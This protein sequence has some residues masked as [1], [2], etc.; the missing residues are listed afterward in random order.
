MTCLL[1]KV[2]NE[3][4][5][6]FICFINNARKRD[7]LLFYKTQTEIKLENISQNFKKYLTI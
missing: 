1:L 3:L 5:Y 2:E 7:H 4:K 6:G